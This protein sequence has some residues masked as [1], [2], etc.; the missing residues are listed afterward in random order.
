L[1]NDVN[2]DTDEAKQ[3]TNEDDIERDSYG[4]E[5]EAQRRWRERME[6]YY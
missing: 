1:S 2:D 3:T 6:N 5:S 4:Y